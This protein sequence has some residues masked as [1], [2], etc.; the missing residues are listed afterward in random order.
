[1]DMWF[2]AWHIL[3]SGSLMAPFYAASLAAVSCCA[4][5]FFCGRFPLRD[6]SL[7]F[8]RFY[9]AAVALIALALACPDHLPSHPLFFLF[10]FFAF[11]GIYA[12]LRM[13]NAFAS[14]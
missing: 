4:Y 13:R 6:Q 3:R 5:D 8:R 9:F 2:F 10:Y 14:L 11:S 1:M 12:S 7:F